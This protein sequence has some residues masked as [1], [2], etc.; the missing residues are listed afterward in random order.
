MFP[1]TSDDFEREKGK[2]KV[3]YFVQDHWLGRLK[4]ICDQEGF[5]DIPQ[6]VDGID[7]CLLRLCETYSYSDIARMFIVSYKTVRLHIDAAS[8][9]NP[10]SH[11][12]GW[13][14]T[15]HRVVYLGKE[16]TLPQLEALPETRQN[17]VSYLN[18]YNRII[19]LGWPVYEA[20]NTPLGQ[21]RGVMD[22]E[23]EKYA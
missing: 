18:L 5:S 9:G 4:I 8:N 15:K 13:H 6:T 1:G 7:Q 10:P 11:P 3:T 14:V 21:P 20:V 19:I 12:R 22:D 16:Y 2:R 23:L 17:N